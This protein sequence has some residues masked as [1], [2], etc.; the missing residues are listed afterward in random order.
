MASGPLTDD[1]E[2]REFLT[3]SVKKQVKYGS[4]SSRVFKAEK[5][6]THYVQPGDTL[7]G[8]ALRYGTAVSSNFPC[9]LY[10][11]PI[12]TVMP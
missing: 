5:Y 11:A 2:E 10:N 4:T 12:Y 9:T 3:S 7:Q 8:L 1:P 6:I